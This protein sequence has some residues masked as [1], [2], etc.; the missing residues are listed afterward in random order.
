M[1]AVD[2]QG[3]PV[4]DWKI[5]GNSRLRQSL[6]FLNNNG[7]IVLPDDWNSAWMLK[8]AKDATGDDGF[9]LV[10]QFR[11]EDTYR[12]LLTPD[13]RRFVPGERVRVLVWNNWLFRDAKLDPTKPVN[14]E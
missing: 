12:E 9:R 8:W 11:M 6:D 5:P 3:D 10:E 14:P 4:Y 7:M 13:V 1:G 2:D